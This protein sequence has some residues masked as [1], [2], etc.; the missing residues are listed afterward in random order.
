VQIPVHLSADLEASDKNAR[1]PLDCAR[2]AGH[3][4]T[5]AL[6]QDL[7]NRPREVQTLSSFVASQSP[8]INGQ[9]GN[10]HTDSTGLMDTESTIS[11]AES[12]SIPEA[13]MKVMEQ[14]DQMGWHQ[15]QWARGFTLLH[16]AAKNDHPE[17]CARFLFQG[18][19]P[20]V[21]DDSGRSALDYAKAYGSDAALA[22]LERGPAAEL[23]AK[24]DV[25][26]S[27]RE[28]Q[29]MLVTAQVTEPLTAPVASPK[30]KGAPP[31]KG[32]KGKGK[33]KAKGKIPTE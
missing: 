32:A 8:G 9:A 13:Y 3:D 12:R 21:K 31:G 24:P 33:G 17:L 22:E 16:W 25:G 20:S 23:P 11:A 7:M 26:V 4:E 29:S 6:L 27:M 28:R 19:D 14:I 30:G 15:M 18:A 1:S 5:A 10:S 2:D